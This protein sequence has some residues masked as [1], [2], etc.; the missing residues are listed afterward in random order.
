MRKRTESSARKAT[1]WARRGLWIVLGLGLVVLIVYAWLPKP[2][3]VE[4]QRAR[5]GDMRVTIVETGKTRVKDRYI[6]S[7]PLMGEMQRVELDPGD[8]VEAGAVVTRIVPMQP[9][10]LDTRTRMGAE[11]RVG[12]ALA[13]QLQSR[14][15]VE[16]AQA[17]A[18]QAQKDLT[19]EERLAATGAVSP[20]Q[21]DQARLQS[22]LR[23]T[24][25]Q[26]AKFASRV[27][28]HEVL[29]AQAAVA[30]F[31]A[32]KG[33]EEVEVTAPVSGRVLRV[34]QQSG[35]VIAAGAPIL[36]VGDPAALEIVTDV[37]TSDAVRIA[38]GSHAEIERWGGPPLPAH[39]RLIEPSAF[40][41]LSA[42]G[43]EEQ[44][45]NVILDLDAP[46][47]QW[48]AMGDGY[49]I[50]ARMVV[51]E[52]P[53]VLSVPAGAVFRHGEGWAVYTVDDNVIHLRDV[54]VGERGDVQVQITGGLAENALLV[55][56]P[57]D[58]VADGVRAKVR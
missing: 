32:G 7:A 30:R 18:D 39:V 42:L 29:L 57:S 17:A 46:R 13:A 55:L 43:V 28:D 45:V 47:E 31:K 54:Q 1:R 21:V 50:E 6:V 15:S 48:L 10:L 52:Q 3:P 49:R 14:A 36:E 23:D 44:R 4:T 53:D 5:K 26:S 2:V 51:W 27:A 16:R 25:L 20:H 41:R 37:L 38:P 58:R 40:T 9:A 34:M 24:E 35:G 8:G 11:T 19:E 56:H 33:S 22:R 12:A